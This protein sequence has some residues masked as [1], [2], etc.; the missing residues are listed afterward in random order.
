MFFTWSFQI[1]TFSVRS[2]FIWKKFLLILFSFLTDGQ[3][4]A[5]DFGARIRD[6]VASGG[7][8]VMPAGAWRVAR[9]E[10]EF[11]EDEHRHEEQDRLQ[12]GGSQPLVVGN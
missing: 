3:Y 11:E 5:E 7:A 12:W 4:E 2:L 1:F 8:D 9:A 6:A 10:R